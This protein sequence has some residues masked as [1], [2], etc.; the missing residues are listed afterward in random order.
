MRT[1]KHIAI[2]APVK[3]SHIWMKKKWCRNFV[4]KTND[5]NRYC[6]IRLILKIVLLEAALIVLRFWYNYKQRSYYLG[7]S[8]NNFCTPFFTNISK[9]CFLYNR[10]KACGL[11]KPNHSGNET[12]RSAFHTNHALFLVSTKKNIYFEYFLLSKEVDSAGVNNQKS[13]TFK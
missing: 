5:T 4:L 3:L 7:K 11:N 1:M 6:V 8:T 10:C 13:I 12:K 2:V 9:D